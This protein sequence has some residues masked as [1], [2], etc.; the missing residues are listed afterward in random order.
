MQDRPSAS[1][2]LMAWGIV[3][4]IFP[5]VLHG[6]EAQAGAIHMRVL[7]SFVRCHLCKFV[8]EFHGVS[9]FNFRAVPNACLSATG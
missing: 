4:G 8:S 9:L 7:R 6:L 3:S 1:I 5:A 2:S